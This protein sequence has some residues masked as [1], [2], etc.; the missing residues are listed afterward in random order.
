MLNEGEIDITVFNY[1][2]NKEP[3]TSNI[4]FLP[5]LHKPFEEFP[6]SRPILSSNSS[7]TERIS[8]LV[9]HF[10]NP[11]TS[12]FRS[13]VKDT[14]HFL[15][16]INNLG[17]I[18]AGC[19]LVTLD[20]QSLYTNINL[21]R[22][23]EAAKESLSSSRPQA[24][25]TPSNAN[26]L[27]LLKLVLTKNNF[28]FNGEHFLQIQGASMGSKCSPSF[29]ITHLDK[30]ERNFVYTFHQQPLMWVRYID[31]VFCIFQGTQ[32]QLL[33]FIKHLNSKDVD[34]QFTADF[35]KTQVHF[36][37]TTV[38]LTEGHIK[39]D[40]YCKPTDSHSYLRFNSAHPSKCKQSIPF[41]Q[42]LRIRR[43][44]SDISDFDKHIVTFSR[45]FLNRGYPLSL[46]EQAAIRA[47]RLNRDTLLSP[48]DKKEDD[49]TELIPLI[50]TFHPNDNSLVEVVK[51]N[52]NI[53]G[54]SQTTQDIHSLRVL[55]AYRRP[56]NLRDLLVRADVFPKT[57]AL[58]KELQKRTKSHFL[59]SKSPSL[60][61]LASRQ[62]SILSFTQPRPSARPTK[63]DTHLAIN[64]NSKVLSKNICTSPKCRYCPLINKSGSITCSVTQQT[65]TSK[66]N[67]SCKSSNL[68]YCITCKCCHKQ[69][70]GQTKRTLALRFQGH[71][72]N[73]NLARS[74]LSSQK[75]V[76]A[77]QDTIGSHFACP[78]HNG[79]SDL[80][81]HIV[82]FISLPP[83]SERALQLRLK[84]EK[85]WIHRFRCPAPLGLNIFD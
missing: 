84:V 14:T 23:L 77:S 5:K 63:S 28:K 40:L 12:G 43:I 46:L 10:L 61:G 50:T 35:S 66:F 82:D 70:V 6:S 55:P 38:S 22:G 59:L 83:N 67:V 76:R 71:F 81:I 75:H 51:S 54:K 2:V 44:C 47:R 29:A 25:I 32:Q 9:D 80:S 42:F 53:L 49:S 26:I 78:K 68:I 34:I 15:Q 64:K 30:F 11:P 27:H 69:Y 56:K 72:Y 8:Q 33:D 16:L 20:V 18:P 3:R 17:Q 19:F 24:N 58:Q 37:D 41:S 21:A 52:W 74:D 65:F 36:L 1:L 85:L 73:I 39:T 31:D 48:Q 13:F 79:I 62:T 7:A 57:K 4:Y 45:Y 60:S